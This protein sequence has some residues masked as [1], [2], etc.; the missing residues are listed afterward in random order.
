MLQW[1]LRPRFRRAAHT[2]DEVMTPSH[3]ACMFRMRGAM[4]LCNR[5]EKAGGGPVDLAKSGEY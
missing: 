5:G 2:C 1:S 4:E 3:G